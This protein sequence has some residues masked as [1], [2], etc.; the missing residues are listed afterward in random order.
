[1]TEKTEQNEI[2]IQPSG[3]LEWFAVQARSRHE[4]KVHEQL[5]EKGM[6]S[7]LPTVEKMRRW[8]DR[9]KIV[10]FPLFSGY[11]FVH[12]V[13]S[14]L[15]ILTIL[16]TRG[17]VRILGNIGNELI[18]VPNEQIGLLK[19]LIEDRTEIDPYPFLKQGERVRIKK[20]P[21]AGVEG[22]L[23]EK[24]G[25]HKVIISVDIIQQSIA[26]TININ[27]IETA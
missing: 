1:M 12:I 15:S 13:R 23:V 26:I 25:R 27:D 11:L 22:I 17:V 21:L 5:L 7:F 3:L 16:K 18:P 9:N 2:Q 6:E 10:E 20:G 14:H 24:A 8:K 4:F 19:K